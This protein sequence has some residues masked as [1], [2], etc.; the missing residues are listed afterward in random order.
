M[1]L[2][3]PILTVGYKGYWE[4]GGGISNFGARGYFVG[5]RV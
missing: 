1:D 4:V 5:R 2:C 3:G